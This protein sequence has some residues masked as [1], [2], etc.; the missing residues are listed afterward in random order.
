MSAFNWTSFLFTGA[1]VLPPVM[2]AINEEAFA[3]ALLTYVAL[4]IA[5]GT[6]AA[7]AEAAEV[8]RPEEKR[9]RI[10]QR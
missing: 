5:A 10:D 3:L 9:G 7:H 4:M 6:A 2:V 8:H 1:C